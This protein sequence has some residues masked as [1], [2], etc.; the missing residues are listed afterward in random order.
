MAASPTEDGDQSF[1][2][3]AGCPA[4]VRSHKK[5]CDRT[6]EAA[7]RMSPISRTPGGRSH[8]GGRSPLAGVSRLFPTNTKGLLP[9]PGALPS[10]GPGER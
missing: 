6:C 8:D 5:N 9:H 7:G 3:T 4:E 1:P 10:L 2:G